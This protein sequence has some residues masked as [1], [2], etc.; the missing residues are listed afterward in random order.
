[1]VDYSAE[2]EL[3]WS[4]QPEDCDQWLY[5][6]MAW[7]PVMSGVRQGSFLE[8][9]LLNIIISD[10]DYGIEYTVHK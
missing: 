3:A 5:V 1:M 7:K 9:L 10:I 8:P 4:S 2:K 6:H